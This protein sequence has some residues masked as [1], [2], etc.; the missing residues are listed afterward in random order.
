MSAAGALPSFLTGALAPEIRGD[1]HVSVAGL[2]IASAAF[3]TSSSVASLSLGN[4]A[5]RLGP[6]RTVRWAGAIGSG[7]MLAVAALAGTFGV[8]VA[9]L[10]VAG[11]ANGMVQPALNAL[12]AD[13]VPRERQGLAFGLKQAAIPAA[14]LLAGVSVPVLALTVGWRY[15]FVA[16]ALLMLL[17]PFLLPRP[18]QRVKATGGVLSD[19]RDTLILLAAVFVFGAMGGNALGVFF[20]SAAVESGISV[21]TAGVL[22]AIGSLLSIVSRVVAGWLADRLDTSAFTIALGLLVLGAFGFGLMALGGP[23]LLAVG[24]MIAFAGGWGWT[25]LVTLAVVRRNPHA[26]AAATGVT[27][28]GVYVGAG[29]GPAFFGA[30]ATISFTTAWIVMGVCALSA[31]WL[32]AYVRRMPAARVPTAA[33]QA[34]GRVTQSP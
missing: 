9:C 5:D 17:A 19:R 32:V 27:Q 22:L 29:V 10:V 26:P 3:F 7:G 34:V 6:T 33:P 18:R 30:L 16:G 12:I 25:G 31:I 2:G 4:L 8:F 21:G 20:V 15:A 24:S 14:A 28:V 13:A 11:V 23:T 1:L